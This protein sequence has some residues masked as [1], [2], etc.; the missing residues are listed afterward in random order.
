ME[1]STRTPAELARLYSTWSQA[2]AGMYRARPTLVFAVLG[3]A[4]ADARL[5]PEDESA[6]IGK[7]LTYWALKTVLSTTYECALMGANR[8]RRVRQPPISQPQVWPSTKE[9]EMNESNTGKVTIYVVALV[10]KIPV[11]LAGAEVTISSGPS[12][13]TDEFGAHTFELTEG[14]YSASATF[15]LASET[16]T[17]V[18]KSDPVDFEISKVRPLS[19][20][21]QSTSKVTSPSHSRRTIS[22]LRRPHRN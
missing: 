15:E 7:L 2:P 19:R 4:R 20:R 5:S 9:D 12:E 21:S 17:W 6:L 14:K 3:Q 1:V 8:S 22:P 11:A 10:E 16:D 18:Y 13:S